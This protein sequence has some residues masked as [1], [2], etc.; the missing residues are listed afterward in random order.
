MLSEHQPPPLRTDSDF[1]C[2]GHHQ[3]AGDPAAPVPRSECT[4]Q[5]NLKCK[6][7]FTCDGLGRSKDY[8]TLSTLE[9]HLGNL[10]YRTRADAERVVAWI[11][12]RIAENK[13]VYWIDATTTANGLT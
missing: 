1:Q 7:I 5:D 9:S 10:E 2:R 13:A 8:A 6:N 4:N 12:K 3:T 11:G